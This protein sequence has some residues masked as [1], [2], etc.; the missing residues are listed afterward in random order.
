[1][2]REYDISAKKGACSEAFNSIHAPKD[3][4]RATLS[5]KDMRL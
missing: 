2:Y 1:M 3:T 5:P 4:S